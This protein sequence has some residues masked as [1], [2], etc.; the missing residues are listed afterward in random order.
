[1]DEDEVDYGDFEEEEE[2]EDPATAEHGEG[3]SNPAEVAGEPADW[4]DC[5]QAT[6]VTARARMRAEWERREAWLQ[7]RAEGQMSSMHTARPM[8]V[9]ACPLPTRLPVNL[10]ALW[11]PPADV[12]GSTIVSAG[13]REAARDA[14]PSRREIEDQERAREE[15]RRAPHAAKSQPHPSERNSEQVYYMTRP[16]L[17]RDVCRRCYLRAGHLSG[18]CDTPVECLPCRSCGEQ[19]HVASR[20]G[21]RWEGCTNCGDR[22]HLARVCRSEQQG[23]ARGAPPAPPCGIC[24]QQG[25]HAE[26]C[27]A[28]QVEQLQA[29]LNTAIEVAALK[30][31]LQ[32]VMASSEDAVVQPP[33]TRPRLEVRVP[34]SG[35]M[36][37]SSRTKQAWDQEDRMPGSQS[38]PG[39][40][41][42]L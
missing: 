4:L 10:P 5:R 2:Q 14:R 16:R 7:G 17:P 1:M 15:E 37:M 40:G 34:E 42:L 41:G 29:R 11:V 21:R 27:Q 9:A 12:S 18:T 3:V 26:W 24:R 39:A 25:G 32:A 20:C 36:R 19:G 22:G 33:A 13:A 31:R 28:E 38:R 6:R 8:S 30:R 35:R 23:P